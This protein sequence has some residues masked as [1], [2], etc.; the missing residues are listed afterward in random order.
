MPLDLT[1]RDY[2]W[3]KIVEV[4]SGCWVWTGACNSRGYGHFMVKTRGVGKNHL[5]HRAVYEFVVGVV[6]A[7]H[8]LHHRCGTRACVNP[9]HLEPLTP[10]Q[11]GERH[12]K[13]HCAHGHPIDAVSWARNREG[14]RVPVRRCN[15][16]ARLRM[17]ARYVP[18]VRADT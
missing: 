12:R 4:P 7:R 15:T 10:L 9:A 3:A 6:P 11:H 5:A 8:H 2:L 16:C 14:R 13:T 17:R 1:D 18:R